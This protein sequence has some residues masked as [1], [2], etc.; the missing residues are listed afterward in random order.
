MLEGMSKQYAFAATRGSPSVMLKKGGCVFCWCA[1]VNFA[2][3]ALVS[4]A[5]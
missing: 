4:G 3:I 5:L 1:L 2:V